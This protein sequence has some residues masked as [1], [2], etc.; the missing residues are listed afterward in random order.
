MIK[1]CHL[2]FYYIKLRF[3]HHFYTYDPWTESISLVV[4]S[5]HNASFVLASF[6]KCFMIERTIR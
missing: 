3:Y 4:S 1:A 6:F 5:V 2:G